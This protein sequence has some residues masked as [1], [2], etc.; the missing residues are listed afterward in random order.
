[1]T[2]SPGNNTHGVRSALLFFLTAFLLATS[3]FA[4]VCKGGKTP[5]SEL[6]AYDARAPRSPQETEAALATHL[7]WGQPACSTLPPQNEHM[8]RHDPV[9]R[10][11]QWAAYRFAAAVDAQSQPVPQDPRFAEAAFRSAIT[12]WAYGEYWRLYA[13]GTTESRAALAERDFADQMEKGSRKPGIGF[14]VLDVRIAGF[15]ALVT[16]KVRMEYGKYAPYARNRPPVPGAADETIQ[17]MLN[18]EGG[19]WRVN[20][21]QFVG[22]SGY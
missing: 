5:G 14:E 1:M 6:R 12:A 21:H 19:E 20:L 4:E 18:Y 9:N 3:A 15:H 22:M 11:A 2:T 13:M 10:V 8:V 17:A 7:P 16:A